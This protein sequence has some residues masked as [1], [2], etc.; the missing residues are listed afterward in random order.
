MG[1]KLVEWYSNFHRSKY[2]KGLTQ[3]LDELQ[4]LFIQVVILLPECQ[5]G[6][7]PVKGVLKLFVKP[8][9]LVVVIANPLARLHDAV[10]ERFLAGRVVYNIESAKLE[11]SHAAGGLVYIAERTGR[12]TKLHAVT[13]KTF[14]NLSIRGRENLGLSDKHTILA[15]KTR[16]K[17]A[18]LAGVEVGVLRVF[19]LTGGTVHLN[20]FTVEKFNLLYHLV[21][22]IDSAVSVAAFGLR[23]RAMDIHVLFARFLVG[24]GNHLVILAVVS[25]LLYDELKAFLHCSLYLDPMNPRERM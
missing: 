24:L 2:L 12:N 23:E 4:T 3:F 11:V 25:R 7:N 9:V 22:W 20:I 13:Q 1:G 16:D 10:D 19:Q 14:Y 18:S 17:M 6:G 8:F 15:H 21:Q 5:A